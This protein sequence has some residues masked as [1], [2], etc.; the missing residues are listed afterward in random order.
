MSP[1]GLLGSAAEEENLLGGS[2]SEDK[3]RTATEGS[4]ANVGHE[5]LGLE[6]SADQGGVQL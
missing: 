2:G 6:S 4:F 3:A 5:E 1:E